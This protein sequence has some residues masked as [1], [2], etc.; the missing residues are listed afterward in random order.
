MS[1]F[2]VV[3]TRTIDGFNIVLSVTPESMEPDWDFETEEEKQE[4]FDKINNGSFLWFCAK[5][6]ANK[7]GIELAS[8]YLGGCCYETIEEFI[9]DAYFEGMVDQTIENAKLAINALTN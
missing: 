7:N 4:L 6:T 1:H 5:V 3:D 2:E 9:K 8:D